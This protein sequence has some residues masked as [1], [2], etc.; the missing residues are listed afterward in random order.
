MVTEEK[1]NVKKNINYKYNE[2]IGKKVC[3]IAKK[4]GVLIRPLGDTIV[5]MPPVSI[6]QKELKKLTRTIYKSIKVATENDKP[7]VRV[8]RKVFG[9]VSS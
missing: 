9:V 8:V 7:Q 3:D 1:K 5:I 4:D 6:K 2:R